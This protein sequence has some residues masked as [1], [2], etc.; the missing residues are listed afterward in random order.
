MPADM[1][2]LIE[3]LRFGHVNVQVLDEK[4]LV[5]LL[6]YALP[7]DVSRIVHQEIGRRRQNN[8]EKLE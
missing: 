2:M 6:D 5:E 7:N 3:N 4:V 1:G 8:L